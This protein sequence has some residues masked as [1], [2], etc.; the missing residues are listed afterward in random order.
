VITAPRS[1]LLLWS[2]LAV[3]RRPPQELENGQK[4]FCG[5]HLTCI[6][7][8]PPPPPPRQQCHNSLQQ[9]WQVTLIL[10]VRRADVACCFFSENNELHS[11]R[12]KQLLRFNETCTKQGRE[13]LKCCG[14]SFAKYNEG[15]ARFI[16]YN[17]RAYQ[18]G[19]EQ[20]TATNLATAPNTPRPNS[21]A[22]SNEQVKDLNATTELLLLARRQDSASVRPS[23]LQKLLT[24]SAHNVK[25]TEKK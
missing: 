1:D 21:S 9:L 17:A 5:Q 4:G 11:Q 16:I 24:P 6:Y 22:G 7:T 13:K 2:A 18:C 20:K 23:E 15:H 19:E 10:K 3:H 14:G 25:K 12:E 8:S